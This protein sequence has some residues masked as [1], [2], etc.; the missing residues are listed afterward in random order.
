MTVGCHDV[1]EK[2]FA[3]QRTPDLVERPG[4]YVA[5][6]GLWGSE[7]RRVR[8]IG[9]RELRRVRLA[10]R[11]IVRAASLL[12]VIVND[13]FAW[14]WRRSGKGADEGVR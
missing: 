2:D 14:G 10:N 8:Q 4:G 7:F 13:R 5:S 6:E 9:D 11:L 12:G 1:R 3:L